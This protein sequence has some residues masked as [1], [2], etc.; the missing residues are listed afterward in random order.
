MGFSILKAGTDVKD[1]ETETGSIQRSRME[2]L[3]TYYG[4]K[5]VTIKKERESGVRKCQWDFSISTKGRICET[6]R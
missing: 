2:N 3:T 4:M 5:V 6:I 1:P